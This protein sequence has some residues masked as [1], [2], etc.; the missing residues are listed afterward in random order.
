MITFHQ[1]MVHRNTTKQ[2]EKKQG[3]Q[4]TTPVLLELW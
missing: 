4:E 1:S 2:A 3:Q